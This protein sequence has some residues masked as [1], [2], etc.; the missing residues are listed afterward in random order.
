MT[1]WLSTHPALDATTPRPVTLGAATGRY[2][3]VK[4][5]PHWKTAPVV[6]SCPN[7][8]VLVTREPDGPQG[9][10]IGPED[11]IRFYVLDLPDGATVTIVVVNP[12]YGSF[13]DLIDQA[14]PVVESFNFRT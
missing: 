8:L 9:W 5:A 11:K 2:V 13:Q 7:G 1:S 10:G 6:T 4:V 12:Y 14:A 3:D